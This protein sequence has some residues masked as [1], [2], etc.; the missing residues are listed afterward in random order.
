LRSSE[1]EVIVVDDGSSDPY[2]DALHHTT[3]LG[4][5]SSLLNGIR[6]S[7]NDVILTMDGDGQH[8]IK[9]VHNLWTVWNMLK[10]DMIIGQRRLSYEEPLRVFARKTLNL[11]ASFFTGRYMYDLNSGMRIFRKQLA[12]DY[13]LILCKTFSF[14][15]SL[16]ISCLCDGYTIEWFPI[17]VVE[18]RYGKTRVRFLKDGLVTLYYILRIG[19]A[20]R[21]RRIRSWLRNLR[22]KIK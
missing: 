8:Q 22:S 12:I 13:S 7:T 16:T 15:T 10:T 6:C 3:N 2:P 17:E 20:L 21:T 11:I 4:Y 1:A 5:G 14:T 18:R 19:I 9:D